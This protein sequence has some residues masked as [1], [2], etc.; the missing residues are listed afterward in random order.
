VTPLASDELRGFLARLLG[1]DNPRAVELA[2]RSLELAV[3][4]RA[5]LVLCGAG[6]AAQ[7]ELAWVDP[8]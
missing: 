2:I 4:H 7:T 1:W 6:G 3:D 5:E 8:A